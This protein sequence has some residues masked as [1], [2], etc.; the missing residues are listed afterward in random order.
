MPLVFPTKFKATQ[1]VLS[2]LFLFT[3][4]NILLALYS[5][6]GSAA[7]N[8]NI[9]S[10]GSYYGKDGVS[11]I[12]GKLS[13]LTLPTLLLSQQLKQDYKV[14]GYHH[15]EDNDFVVFQRSI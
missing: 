15:N 13:S 9:K 6:D 8:Q 12:F 2:V 11:A 7:N 10:K 1:I 3:L 5:T 14:V 4:I